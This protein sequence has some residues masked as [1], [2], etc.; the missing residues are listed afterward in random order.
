MAVYF[1]DSS[2]VTKRYVAE[3]GTTW[4]TK[5]VL[6]SAGN[7]IHLAS[8]TAVEVTAA[9]VR[10]QRGGHLTITELNT[11]LS[12]LR[13]DWRDFQITSITTAL[14]SRATKLAETYALRGYDA[15]QLAAALAVNDQYLAAN[16]SPLTLISANLEL[17]VAAQAEDLAMDNP[18]A[19]P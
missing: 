5:I 10:R 16:L 12:Q 18:N 14:I 1:V 13:V 4:M 6:P 7:T 9:L 11:A 17:N 8:I 3:T 15:V 2:A 19:H